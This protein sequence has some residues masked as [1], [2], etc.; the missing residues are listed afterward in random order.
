M[1]FNGDYKLLTHLW[2]W[3]VLLGKGWQS[4]AEQI[5]NPSRRLLS[6]YLSFL[7]GND[8]LWDA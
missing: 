7:P 1:F 5:T 2:I 4:K 6:V 8:S 3:R